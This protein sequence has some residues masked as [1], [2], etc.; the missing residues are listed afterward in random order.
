[1]ATVEIGGEE[2]KGRAAADRLAHEWSDRAWVP[3][4]P[5]VD[6]ARAAIVR[7]GEIIAAQPSMLRASM[8][9]AGKG[10]STLSP[11]PFQGLVECLQ[12]ADDLGAT[13][14]R[15]AYRMSPRP[16][17]LI[18]HDGSPV[19]LANVGA[20][21][22][23]WLSTKGDD[24]EASGRFGI[25][26]RTLS[27]LGGPIEIH[28]PP[29][30]FVMGD[31]GPE[32]CEP[33]VDVESVYGAALRHT[34]LVIPLLP[35]V[36]GS[37]IAEAVR[38]LNVDSLIFLKSIRRLH[39]RNFED[40]S[41][42]LDFAIEVTVAGSGEIHFEGEVAE[43]D[44]TEVRVLAPS[45]EAERTR[46]RR[47][48]TRRAV[49]PDEKRSNKSTG[50]STPIAICVPLAKARPLRL[51]DRMPLPVWTGL[52]IGLNAQFDPDSAR[53]TLQPN[54]WNIARFADLGRLVTWAAMNEFSVGRASS[55]SHVPL[56]AEADDGEGW[57]EGQVRTLVAYCHNA[58]RE[59]LL[60]RTDAGPTALADI[61]YEHED[62]E[63]LLT[64]ADV[65][66][67]RPN[68]V[69]MPR[70]GRD[71][72]GRWRQVLDELG[73]CEVVEVIDALNVVDGQVERGAEWYVSFAALAER[74][75]LTE[76]FSARPGI[77]LDGGVTTA[78]PQQGDPWV[79]VRKSAPDALATRL[80]L[81]RRIHP[82]YLDS[83]APTTTFLS[84][85]EKLGV[86]F[87]DRDADGDV[88]AVLGRTPATGAGSNMPLRL[89]DDDLI[90]LR[91]AWARLAR[92]QHAALGPRIGRSIELK[93][94][95]YGVD[96]KRVTGWAR[97]IE[98]YLPAAIDREVDSFAK[99]AGRAPGIKWVDPDYARLLKQSAGRSAIGA[100]R[101]LAAWGVAREPRLVKPADE[102][103]HW[104]RDTTPASSVGHMQTSEQLHAVRAGRNTHLIDDHWSP[105]AD[106]VAADI[107]K[108]SVKLRR[109]RAVAFLA[110]LSRRW[111]RLYSEA[112]TA[113]PAYAYNGYWHRSTEV[114][115]T[116]LARLADVKWMPDSANG[117]Q[118]PSELQLQVQGSPPRPS[119]R[120]TT[121]AKLDSQILR[122][123]VLAAL[124]VKAGPTQRDLVARLQALRKEEVT[125]SVSKEASSTYQLLAASL[126]DRSEGGPE[127]R[128]TQAQLRNAFRAGI[129]GPGLL[130]VDGQWNSPEQVFRGPALFGTRRAFAPHVEGLEPLWITLGVHLPSAADAIAVL[131][132]IAVG[133][134]SSADLGIA[135]CAYT[136]I[137]AEV[138]KMSS[139]LRTTLK[140]LPLWTGSAWVTERPV[141]ALESEALLASAAPEM[142]VWR[143]GITSFSAVEALLPSL[144]VV[145]LTPADFQAVSTPAYGLTEGELLRPVF[146]GAISLLR[147]E[148]VRADQVLLDSLSID[149]DELLAAPVVIDPQLSIVANLSSSQVVLPARAHIS[150]EPL[151]L[152]V[153]EAADLA[154]AEGAGAAV[155]SL[156]SGDRQKAAWAWASIWPRAAAG[157]Q[158]KGAVM[159]KRRAERGD[160][161]ERLERLAKQ[162]AQRTKPKEL[163][164]SEAPKPVSK[165]PVQVRKLRELED[166]EPSA[167]EIVNEGAKPSGGMVFAKRRAAKPRVFTD[168]EAKP[169][170]H[171]APQVRTV[172][173]PSSDR[174]RM[175]LDAVRRALRLDE[176]QINDLRAARGVGI[177][178]IDELRQCYEIKMS[179]GTDMPCDVTLTASEVEAAQN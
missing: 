8:R 58:L 138:E 129:D 168:G 117:L 155:A 74:H 5:S 35:T 95:W 99:A 69:A 110:T 179:S 45:Q 169:K 81:A 46:Y 33:E 112:A 127:G 94:M 160:G 122:S 86:L 20:M 121:V 96:G 11:R 32:P 101:L 16:E 6:W 88:F 92:D 142:R 84:T 156:F 174:E 119:E 55:W 57:T 131:K 27:S 62:L 176:R 124:G 72:E 24:P 102:R 52:S 133:E 7:L 141:Y 177:D 158:A 68:S 42:D 98:T 126:R 73:Q 120:S 9:G 2:E 70:G 103:A 164:K 144:G 118:R 65:E 30:H 146:A 28:A 60:I 3:L 159:P 12:N 105:D 140:R 137:A 125:A 139:Q 15:I 163:K 83:E 135:I 31:D 151:R 111:D 82:A 67:L 18:T 162:A 78:R 152:I 75:Q 100:Q 154:T 148:L 157:E 128:M 153:R 171:G 56:G 1:M 23:P 77:L 22:L 167:G 116:W 97:P 54:D 39:F 76:K 108:S 104:A 90:A 170:Q 143:T 91:G 89:E 109:K 107:A 80:G 17:L 93:A 114:R 79:L 50:S 49:G 145:R 37:A 134:P 150:H 53:S 43:V 38:E 47:Y 85:L 172:L 59:Q 130:L 10:A 26:Q 123:G 66:R 115:A 178:A 51:Y 87:D 19:T 48:S 34:M 13:S 64:E 25:G 44:V 175:A 4:D 41:Q 40:P 71:A 14:M 61:A 161:K 147:Q 113:I 149:W 173:P 132:E 136:L 36:S 106:I 63:A 29:F 166:L 165:Q 21:L